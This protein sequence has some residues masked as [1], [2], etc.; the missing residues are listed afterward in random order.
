MLIRST[1]TSA[2]DRAPRVLPPIDLEIPA[3]LQT[4]T[5]ASG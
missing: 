5:F 3:G 2:E 1:N 4:A